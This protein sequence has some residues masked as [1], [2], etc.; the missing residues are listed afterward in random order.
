MRFTKIQWDK[1]RVTLRWQTHSGADTEDHELVSEDQPAPPFVAALDKFRAFVQE[2]CGFGPDWIGDNFRIRAVSLSENKDGARQ[3]VMHGEKQVAKAKAPFFFTTPMLTE[4]TGELTGTGFFL[5]GMDEAIVA[6]EK[7][8]TEYKAGM[9]M[10]RQLSLDPPNAKSRVNPP[11]QS[12]E[13][14]S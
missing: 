13:V 2:V 1:K 7:T 12:A 9:R 3:L 14:R 10:Q 4:I 11:P 6:L 5:A 8:A